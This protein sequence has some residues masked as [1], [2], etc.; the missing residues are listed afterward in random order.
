MTKFV[1]TDYVW[2]FW[3]FNR[4]REKK[5]HRVPINLRFWYLGQTATRPETAAEFSKKLNVQRRMN[6]NR[7]AGGGLDSLHIEPDAVQV[8]LVNPNARIPVTFDDTRGRVHYIMYLPTPL[9]LGY[10]THLLGSSRPR[11]LLQQ[12]FPL[13]GV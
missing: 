4:T 8:H 10:L 9:I 3:N 13:Y 6:S 2:I 12:L 7:R 1:I 11:I 5:N